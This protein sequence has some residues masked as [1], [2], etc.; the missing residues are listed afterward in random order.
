MAA[1]VVL[2]MGLG[3]GL[4]AVAQAPATFASFTGLRV[5]R[6]GEGGAATA[7]PAPVSGASSHAA[8]GIRAVATVCDIPLFSFFLLQRIFLVTIWV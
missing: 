1:G 3:G 2:K 5:C 6:T 4:S 7:A 8:L